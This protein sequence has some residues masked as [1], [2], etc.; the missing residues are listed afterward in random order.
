MWELAISARAAAVS[1][2]SNGEELL[3][4]NDMDLVARVV[5]EGGVV[6]RGVVVKE[7][8]V[9]VVVSM[10]VAMGG[11]AMVVAMGGVGMVV[12]M[13]GVVAIVGANVERFLNLVGG[14]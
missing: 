3:P 4:S 10:V 8:V 14:V 7:I 12:C 6:A 11:V 9:E 1:G 5:A 13:V 2:L